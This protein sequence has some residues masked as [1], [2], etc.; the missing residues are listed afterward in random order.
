MLKVMTRTLR[1][2][3]TYEELKPSPPGFAWLLVNRFQRTYEELKLEH[4]QLL[5]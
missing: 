1:F 2:Q 5:W 4:R 3:R